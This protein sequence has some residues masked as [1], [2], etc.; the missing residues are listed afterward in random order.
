MTTEPL[1]AQPVSQHST[2][3]AEL[4]ATPEELHDVWGCLPYQYRKEAAAGLLSSRR[5]WDEL[6]CGLVVRPF[7]SVI[8]GPPHRLGKDVHRSRNVV[9]NRLDGYPDPAEIARLH[10]QGSAVL[11]HRPELWNPEIAGLVDG[12]ATSLRAKAWSTAVL[13]PAGAHGDPHRE[14]LRAA[15]ETH[16]FVYQL[17]GRTSW[18]V[19]DAAGDAAA[20]PTGHR[21]FQAQQ[22][23]GDLLYLPPLTEQSVDA[24][25][26]GSLSLLVSVQELTARQLAE[27]ML[28][29][30]L[31]ST[32]VADLAGQ[33]HALS[34]TEKMAWVRRAAVEH[35]ASQ[36][37]GQVVRVARQLQQRS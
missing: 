29:L 15:P 19:T 20:A 27:T 34:L 9:N 14:L 6:D 16:T 23:P 25:A 13:L 21:P 17:E 35:L 11:L 10:A 3:P 31:R 2:S 26:D 30:F 7:F 37:L 1:S 24:G 32:P 36:D 4:V 18:T 22:R 8:P 33:H 28:A 12:M 5:I